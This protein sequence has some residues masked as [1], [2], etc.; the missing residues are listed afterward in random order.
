MAS[1]TL[2]ESAVLSNDDL[3][4]GVIENVITVNK[5]FAVLPFDG[6]EGNSLAYNRELLEEQ[7]FD[8]LVRFGGVGAVIGAEAASGGAN[9]RTSK[10]PA[11]FSRVSSDLTTILGDA[12][13]N[14]LIQATRSNFTDQ[15]AVQ[16]ASKAKAA[17]RNYMNTM[18]N[19]DGTNDTFVGLR[20]LVDAAQTFAATPGAAA[21]GQRY[22]LADLDT[23][24]D[25]I[26]DKDGQVDYF[27]MNAVDIRSY[28]TILRSLGGASIGDTVTLPSG[29]EVPGYRGVPVFRNDFIPTNLG[30]GMDESVILAGTMDDGSRQHG[31]VGLTAANASGIQVVEVGE[32]ETR[33]EAITRVKWYCG[34][35]LFSLK[36][37]AMATG[38]TTP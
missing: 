19:G 3:V 1:I 15:T 22:G 30:G 7:D 35:A 2:A 25:L 21:S 24:M 12:E 38:S 16:V 17:G 11:L 8:A 20:N 6:I 14:G 36:G 34:L 33:D 9:P 27:G 5:M 28:F 10:D 18:I 23:L 32:S 31:I 37:L 26:T 4:A 13:V 29:E